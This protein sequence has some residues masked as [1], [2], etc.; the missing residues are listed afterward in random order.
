VHSVRSHTK[1]ILAAGKRTD[2]DSDA[3]QFHGCP[4]HVIKT[5]LP[6]GVIVMSERSTALEDG[7][8]DEQTAAI[9]QHAMTLM[10]LAGAGEAATYLRN[11]EVPHSVIERVLT[12]ESLRRAP[13]RPLESIPTMRV[14]SS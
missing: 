4:A 12:G 9:V 2:Y 13:R 11:N 5:S 10:V 6:E 3:D 1:V 7:R 14:Q 8:R